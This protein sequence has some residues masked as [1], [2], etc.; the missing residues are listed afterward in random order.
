[1]AKALEGIRVID[2]SQVLAGPFATQQ[3]LL[4]GADVIKVEQPG[5]G[6]QSRQLTT[7]DA[8]GKLNLAP[9]FM[10]VNAGKRSITLD[11]KHE[12][13][14]E[15]VGRLVA[16]ADVFI[17]NFKAGVVDRLGFGY[18]ALRAIK[19]DLVYCSIS[20]YGQQ[21]PKSGAA[22]YDG[23]IQAISG[24][25]S[26]NGHAE[27][28]PTRTG[29]TVVDMATGITAAFAI[30]SALFRRSVTGEGQFLDVAMLDSALTFIGPVIASYLTGGKPPELIGNMSPTLLPSAGVFQTRKGPLMVLA[31][32]QPQIKALC[33]ELGLGDLLKDS[34]WNSRAGQIANAAEMAAELAA[35]LATDDAGS[36]EKRLAEV[37][38]PAAPVNSV[39]EAVENP[40]LAH[41]NVLMN[42][43]APPGVDGPLRVAGAGFGSPSDGP[44]TE[45]PP[46][47]VGQH[48]EEVLG[49]IGYGTEEITALRE[50]GAL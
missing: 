22:A 12:A 41:R 30:M 8:L 50:S 32:T 5:G 44:G 43:P 20:G 35:A 28:G 31:L 38:V 9:M 37:G 46:P 7:D 33:K 2:F 34:R 15:I 23:A 13:A 24:M 36:W 16:G 4:L 14:R 18:E 11:L 49:E 27:T 21:G 3:L 48:T 29:Y 19:P 39:A 10:S 26:I 6:D 42:L 45:L 47:T 40:Q 17:Q 25:M 1:M